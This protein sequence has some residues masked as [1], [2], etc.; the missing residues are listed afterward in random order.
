MIKSIKLGNTAKGWFEKI[1]GQW[2]FKGGYNW[3]PDNCMPGDTVGY[4]VDQLCKSGL[5]HQ[6]KIIVNGLFA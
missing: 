3:C 1:K 5:R 2:C 4:V 6:A